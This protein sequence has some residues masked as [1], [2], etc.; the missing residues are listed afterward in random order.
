ML[1]SAPGE[2]R[3]EALGLSL[4]ES[5]QDT[6]AQPW[7]SLREVRFTAPKRAGFGQGCSLMFFL[8]KRVIVSE[9]REG[10][11]EVF[12]ASQEQA[13]GHND[14][15]LMGAAGYTRPCDA[16][17]NTLWGWAVSLKLMNTNEQ[18]GKKRRRDE[19]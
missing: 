3:T 6:Q 5:E 16:E 9:L 4:R 1:T 8:T 11:G 2:A 13:N 10:G 17:A 12:R 15:G 7:Y 14:D 18:M 19:C